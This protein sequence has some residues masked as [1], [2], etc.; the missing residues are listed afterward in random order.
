M[1][2][3][4]FNSLLTGNVNITSNTSDLSISEVDNQLIKISLQTTISVDE[5][6]DILEHQ[7]NKGM[8]KYGHTIDNCPNNK[9]NWTNT[10]LEE[11]VDA[12]V[13]ILKNDEVNN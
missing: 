10:L 12:S 2:S 13:Y 7:Y 1:E 4:I 6:R 11:L 5:Y 8:S 3:K 9:F